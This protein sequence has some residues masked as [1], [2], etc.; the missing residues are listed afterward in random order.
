[1]I[2]QMIAMST[3]FVHKMNAFCGSAKQANPN[4]SKAW[5]IIGTTTIIPV[6]LQCVWRNLSI[7]PVR[8]LPTADSEL[9][10]QT[11]LGWS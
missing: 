2:I 1:M 3:K 5:I 8:P 11:R 9:F 7:V 4:A 10:E 6:R